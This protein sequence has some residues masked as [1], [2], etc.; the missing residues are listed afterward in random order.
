MRR[1]TSF[2]CLEKTSIMAPEKGGENIGFVGDENQIVNAK[3]K[4]EFG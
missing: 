4:G 2:T 1:E 3:G